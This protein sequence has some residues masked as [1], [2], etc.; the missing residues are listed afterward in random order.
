MRN[1]DLVHRLFFFF[2]VCSELWLICANL[3]ITNVGI[4][5]R[6]V[7]FYFYA[8]S[9]SFI[10]NCFFLVLNR[11][12]RLFAACDDGVDTNQQY[13]CYLASLTLFAKH[14][15]YIRLELNIVMSIWT[16]LG[17]LK[18]IY[19]FIRTFC[20]C[21]W[22]CS[23]FT[24]HSEQQP[25]RTVILS[26]VFFHGAFFPLASINKFI[27]HSLSLLRSSFAIPF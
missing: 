22:N 11:G 21:K 5:T 16:W 19:C 10:R 13:R 3:P 7:F 27:R 20:I 24:A 4:G 26:Y 1:D 2:F 23:T 14:I 18:P 25:R 15:V 8:T 9:T 12:R 6:C 17:S